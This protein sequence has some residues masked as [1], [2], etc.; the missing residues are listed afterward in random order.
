[1]PVILDASFAL[2]LAIGEPRS[3]EVRRLLDEWMARGEELC[4]P[5]LFGYELAGVLRNKVH[6]GVLEE[7][8]ARLALDLLLTLPIVLLHPTGLHMRAFEI[9]CD[10]GLP[11]SYDAHYLA[12]AE[13]LDAEMWTLDEWFA[14]RARLLH[15]RVRTVPSP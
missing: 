3:T 12:L 2:A 7:S 4:A 9:A 14:D 11:T 15:F 8:D 5:S 6:R 1:M 13:A 10:L